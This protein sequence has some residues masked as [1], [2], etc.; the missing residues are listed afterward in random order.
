M[1]NNTHYLLRFTGKPFSLWQA[2]KSTTNLLK[3]LSK[4]CLVRNPL[5]W[6][7]TRSISKTCCGLWLLSIK[8]I[9][10]TLTLL[11]TVSSVTMI[12]TKIL[13]MEIRSNRLHINLRTEK[14]YFKPQLSTKTRKSF[15]FCWNYYC[16]NSPNTVKL[17]TPFKIWTPY[18]RYKTKI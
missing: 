17:S 4:I 5:F 1:S 9:K 18:F 10:Q 11:W 7:K 14:Q 12:L 3:K 16:K 8:L 2:K 6:K 13:I 15:Y